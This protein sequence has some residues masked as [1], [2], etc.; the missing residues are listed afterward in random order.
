DAYRPPPVMTTFRRVTGGADHRVTVVPVSEAGV[1][2][3][4]R[5]ETTTELRDKYNARLG[6]NFHRLIA[7]THQTSVLLLE[8]VGPERI[9]RLLRD[10][11][12]RAREVIDQAAL[13]GAKP[14]V[15]GPL[16]IPASP[17]SVT[18]VGSN[19]GGVS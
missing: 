12:D 16:Q 14:R 19:L 3:P 4:A 17:T 8:Q 9:E 18:F 11:S 2:G 15:E 10:V 13:Y 6:F 1:E 5:S 7:D